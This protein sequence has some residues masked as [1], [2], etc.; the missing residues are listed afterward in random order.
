MDN[1]LIAKEKLIVEHQFDS[2][3]KKVL[4]DSL[5]DFK[6]VRRN[7]FKHIQ[8]SLDANS[9]LFD[10][11]YVDNFDDPVAEK[12][13]NYNINFDGIDCDFLNEELYNAVQELSDID[14]SIILY[15]FWENYSE[16]DIAK[17]LNISKRT[18]NYHKNAAYRQMATHLRLSEK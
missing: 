18:V 13:D 16:A 14:R 9:V 2:F 10:M 15:Y 11:N 4:H 12:F 6:R 17:M 8:L 1:N 5:I 7:S 3:S